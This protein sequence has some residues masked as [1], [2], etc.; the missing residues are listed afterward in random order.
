MLIT[1]TEDN[2]KRNKLESLYNEYALYIYRVAYQIL[3]DKYLAQDAV[4]EAFISILKNVD[5]I[6]EINCNKTKAFI[7]IIIRNI[8]INLYNQRKKQSSLSFEE[9][10]GELAES[11]PNVEET[12]ISNE[13]FSRVTDKIKKL[14]PLYADILSLKYYF[15]YKDE[16][17]S[18]MLNITPENTRIRL[19]RARK[20]LLESLSQDQEAT[21]HD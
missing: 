21:N 15:Y 19:H 11:V 3:K 9:L 14:H 4:H 13:A 6:I 7:I 17:I 1:F 5:K 2:E 20:Y 18:K 16:E 8:S 10:E 12:V